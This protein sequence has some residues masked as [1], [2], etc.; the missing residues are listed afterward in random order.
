MIHPTN[1]TK[2]PGLALSIAPLAVHPVYEPRA[3]PNQ[4]N[5]RPKIDSPPKLLLRE[6][7]DSN[8]RSPQ[9]IK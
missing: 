9:N 8:S 5:I 6:P 1:L 4:I 3:L 2:Q 7:M